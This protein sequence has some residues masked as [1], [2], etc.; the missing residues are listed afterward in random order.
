MELDG[1]FKSSEDE[2]EEGSPTGFLLLISVPASVI[3]KWTLH[4]TMW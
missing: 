1:E 3:L 4:N 2:K